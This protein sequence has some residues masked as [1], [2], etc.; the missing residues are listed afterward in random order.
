MVLADHP[1]GSWVLCSVRAFSSFRVG[2]TVDGAAEL[3]EQD[4]K[5]KRGSKAMQEVTRSRTDIVKHRQMAKA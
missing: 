1:A 4:A 3:L 5:Q 2:A